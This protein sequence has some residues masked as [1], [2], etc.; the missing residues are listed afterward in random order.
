MPLEKS[1]LNSERFDGRDD[2]VISGGW[3]HLA[4]TG[5]DLCTRGKQPSPRHGRDNNG[6]YICLGIQVKLTF[7]IGCE[8]DL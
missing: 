8:L 7:V 1:H 3:V 5:C 6:E 4:A 2:G